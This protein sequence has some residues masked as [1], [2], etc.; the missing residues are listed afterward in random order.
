MMGRDQDDPFAT[1]RYQSLS[2]R[3]DTSD[4]QWTIALLDEIRPTGAYSYDLISFEYLGFFDSGTDFDTPS[5]SMFVL[6]NALDGEALV[7]RLRAEGDRFIISLV[8]GEA[9]PLP[10]AGWLFAAM[11]GAGGLLRLVP[12]KGRTC[13]VR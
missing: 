8:G 3:S 2:F 6:E 11:L 1:L 9:I 4:P 5:L 7:G 12:T 13:A 10:A